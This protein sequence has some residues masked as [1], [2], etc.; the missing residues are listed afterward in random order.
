MYFSLVPDI[1]IK[2]NYYKRILIYVEKT[3]T[4]YKVFEKIFEDNLSS[5]LDWSVVNCLSISPKH[6]SHYI[7]KEIAQQ[8]AENDLVRMGRLVRCRMWKAGSVT[9]SLGEFAGGK[10]IVPARSQSTLRKT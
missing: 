4:E 7:L 5:I 9:C 8:Q 3:K 6:S 10:L 1:S 2:Y